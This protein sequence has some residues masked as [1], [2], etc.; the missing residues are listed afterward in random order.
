MDFLAK[1]EPEPFTTDRRLNSSLL[2]RAYD[3]ASTEFISETKQELV[4]LLSLSFKTRSPS[5]GD[6]AKV[7]KFISAFDGLSTP[8]QLDELVAKLI[9]R[10]PFTEASIRESLRRMKALRMFEDR[11]G[12]AGWWRVGQLYKMGLRMKYVR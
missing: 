3:E 8:F 9:S 6:Q 5:D 7:T 4:H 1:N 12:Y 11:P 2:N 10:T